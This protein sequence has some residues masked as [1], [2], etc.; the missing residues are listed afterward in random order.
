L[1]TLVYDILSSHEVSRPLR[2]G[3]ERVLILSD[4]GCRPGWI[5]DFRVLADKLRRSPKVDFENIAAVI[6]NGDTVFTG[7]ERNYRR[8]RRVI[9]QEFPGVHRLFNIGN[10]ELGIPW[11]GRMRETVDRRVQRYQ[12]FFHSPLNWRKVIGG[13][14]Y[15]GLDS[16]HKRLAP[17]T[18]EYLDESL[19]M[20]PSN[21]VL[22]HIPP[23]LRPQ[24]RGRTLFSSD[25]L[26]FLQILDRHPGRVIACTYG[27]IHCNDRLVRNGVV[28]QLA[29]T[30]GA[31]SMVRSHSHYGEASG[32]YAAI[33]IDPGMRG[34]QRVSLITSH[35]QRPRAKAKAKEAANVRIAVSMGV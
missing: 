32:S 16:S 35:A 25:T 11:P 17:G 10:H 15:I 29:G 5:P 6:F 13:V 12:K 26:G 31:M 14:Q 34:A 8:A 18:L 4:T 33:L 1:V 24:W 7:S 9:E 22:I 23:M 3:Q 27:H 21:V 30:G 28:H 2:D 19:S 20:H